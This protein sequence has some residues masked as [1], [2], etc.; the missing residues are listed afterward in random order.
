MPATRAEPDTGARVTFA[1]LAVGL[2]SFSLLQSVVSPLLPTMRREFGTSQSAIAWVLVSYLLA[3]TVAT[4]I[5]GRLADRHGKKRMLLVAFGTL[6]VGAV[7]AAAAPNIE[8][9]IVARVLQGFGGGLLPIAYSIVR[10][11]FRPERVP[12]V[13]GFMAALLAGGGAVGLVVAGPIA[14]TLGYRWLF[15]LAAVVLA[16]ATTL[17]WKFVPDSGTRNG[18]RI[19]TGSALLL[20]AW[21]TVLLLG[22]SLAPTEGWTSPTVLGLLCGGVVFFAVWLVNDARSRSPLVDLRTLRL[23]TVW[24]TNISSLMFGAGMYANFAIMPQFLQTPSASGY[25]FG[26]SI[27]ESGL[28][29]LPQAAVMF[30]TGC[31]AGAVIGRFGERTTLALGSCLSLAG[32]VWLA[33]AHDSVAHVMTGTGLLGMGFGLGLASMTTI[34]VSTVPHDQ[35]GVASGMNANVRTMGGAFGAA[36]VSSIIAAQTDPSGTPRE[37]AFVFAFA[38]LAGLLL[39]SAVATACL[40]GRRPPALS[41]AR[42]VTAAPSELGAVPVVTRTPAADGTS[43]VATVR[44]PG[45]HRRDRGEFAVSREPVV[46]TSEF[47][48]RVPD[49]AARRG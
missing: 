46:A 43:D 26:A 33:V 22:S 41:A 31:C 38:L 17:A 40:P 47:S 1:V 34:V 24:P 49:G 4:P 7:G 15:V 30:V 25:G 48:P 3:A 14:A 16:A 5:L 37:R 35:T 10:E 21:L 42:A 12:G 27:T 32:Y 29:T 6:V 20:S 23:P 44:R 9:M 28:M 39:V 18:G 36:V 11:T 8:F 19:S 2:G 13:I 45:A